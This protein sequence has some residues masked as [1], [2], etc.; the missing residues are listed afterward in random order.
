[1]LG[2]LL[3]ARAV[4]LEELA[5][6]FD[7][8]RPSRLAAILAAASL[9][10]AVAKT[11]AAGAAAADLHRSLIAD[12]PRLL[13]LAR[14]AIP[15]V[16]RGAPGG[17]QFTRCHEILSEAAVPALAAAYPELPLVAGACA[18]VRA[19][20]KAARFGDPE[21]FSAEAAAGAV[22]STLAGPLAALAPEARASVAVARGALAE[23]IGAACDAA[24]AVDGGDWTEAGPMAAAVTTVLKQ[25]LPT[26]APHLRPLLREAVAAAGS[27]AAAAAA[28]ACIVDG[29]VAALASA[30]WR[31]FGD[32]EVEPAPTVFGELLALLHA[33]AAGAEPLV[34]AAA[35]KAWAA[36]QATADKAVGALVTADHREAAL[37]AS[38][39]LLASL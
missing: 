34:D 32:N 19:A 24:E 20:A 4:S 38:R 3:A 26:F 18:A 30:C 8:L 2:G 37:A 25:A 9:A 35:I 36:P 16:Q 22:A 39:A 21:D 6:A 14:L 28:G 17:F 5:P 13:P 33:P 12:A 1:M 15:Q 7:S 29:A 31:L 10:E 27:G 23:A 11:A